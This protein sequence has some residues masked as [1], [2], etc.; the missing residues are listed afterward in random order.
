MTTTAQAA[1]LWGLEQPW[2]V[3]EI[4]VHDPQEGE[5]H[6]RWKAAGLC[7]SDEHL[8]T[9]DMVP[10]PEMLEMMGVDSFFPIVGGHEGAGIIEDVGPGV[11][12]VNLGDH[13]SASFVPS[14]GHCRYC[15]TGRRQPLRR[16]RR[17]ARRGHDH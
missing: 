2:K 15:T 16:R 4:E 7:H 3:Q 17:H 1:I 9:G 11:N 12:S 10:S 13:V 6:V 5:V 14:C 8:V